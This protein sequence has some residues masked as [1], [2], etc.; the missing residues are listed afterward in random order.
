M[1]THHNAKTALIQFMENMART[2]LSPIVHNFFFLL[3]LQLEVKN[4]FCE[5]FLHSVKI[6]QLENVL[7]NSLMKETK[8][9]KIKLN[10]AQLVATIQNV[11]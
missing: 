9:K 11:K 4:K 7:R 1:I 6:K 2:R 5:I 10:A 3:G 8:I